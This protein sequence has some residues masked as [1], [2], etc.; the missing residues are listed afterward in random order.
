SGRGS[1]THLAGELGGHVLIDCIEVLD[2]LKAFVQQVLGQLIGDGS[3]A[4]L[5]GHRLA[6]DEFGGDC[7]LILTLLLGNH[8]EG[9]VAVLDHGG[10]VAFHVD[11]GVKG[12]G[13]TLVL[14]PAIV[15]SHSAVDGQGDLGGRSAR[16]LLGGGDQE[17]VIL[18]HG[19]G[20]GVVA[21][22]HGGDDG[23]VANA[24]GLGLHR[25]GI[26]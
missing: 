16:E 19:P 1:V 7:N 6:A 9:D 15:H 4:V 12:D 3:H 25:D 21:A 14:L 10:G 18:T 13:A 5:H 8:V 23:I 20:L 24:V 22:V 26:Q 17:V 11:F 2:V